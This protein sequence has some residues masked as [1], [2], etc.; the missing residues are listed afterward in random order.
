MGRHALTRS[1]RFGPYGGNVEILWWLA[2]AAVV[3]VVAMCWAS[4]VGRDVRVEVDREVAAARLGKALAKEHP[5]R[6]A[7]TRERVKDRSSG[8]AVRPSHDP[9]HGTGHG[10]GRTRRAS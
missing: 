3:L 7:V 9:G 5:G 6:A 2:P 1:G 10:T 8:I 4:W